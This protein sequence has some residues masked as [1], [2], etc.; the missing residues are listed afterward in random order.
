MKITM[1]VWQGSILMY[2]IQPYRFFTR[3]TDRYQ[4]NPLTGDSKQWQHRP[5][6]TDRCV[7]VCV[8]VCIAVHVCGV[9][10]CGV[11]ACERERE[12]VSVRSLCVCLCVC[13]MHARERECEVCVSVCVCVWY[14]CEREREWVW[15]VCVCVS[16]ASDSSE[17]V[18]VVIVKLGTVTAL[19]MRMYHVLIILTLPFIQGNRSKL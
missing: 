17:T 13:G 8:C 7:C 2:I 4:T 15:G 12:W 1:A 3:Y 5:P 6:P 14:A 11:H 16:L 19:D 18:E 9:H 10:V